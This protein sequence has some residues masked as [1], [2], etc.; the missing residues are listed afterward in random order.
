M[1]T[2]VRAIGVAGA[3]ATTTL[4]TAGVAGATTADDTVADEAT[5]ELAPR[6]ERACL[7]IPNLTTRT[8]RVLE[9]I[10]GDA[11]TRGSLLWLDDHIAKAEDNGRTGLV[12]FLENR[13]AVREASVEVFE[14][15]LDRLA[16]LADRCAEAGVDL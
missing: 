16:E 8:E 4:L 14:L 3:I 2:K 15:R 11:D 5:T 1:F 6:A 12:E 9:R 7:R 10:G 13:R